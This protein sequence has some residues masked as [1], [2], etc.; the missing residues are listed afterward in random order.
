MAVKLVKN[1]YLHNVYTF[2]FE[3]NNNL[4]FGTIF[5]I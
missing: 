3:K 4:R 5:T 1:V 2:I